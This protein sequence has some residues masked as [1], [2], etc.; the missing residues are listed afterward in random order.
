MID[1][2]TPTQRSM[3]DILSDGRPHRRE[4]LHACLPDD[5]G[6]LS[7][8]NPHLSLMRKFLNPHGLQIVALSHG[9]QRAIQYQLVRL[10]TSPMPGGAV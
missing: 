1:Q 8:I 9:K 4:E 2:L 3:Y 7:N 5:Q 6:S 10:V